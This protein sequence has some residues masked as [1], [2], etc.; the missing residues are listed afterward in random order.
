M[1]ETM[2][3]LMA[4]CLVFEGIEVHGEKDGQLFGVE[5]ISLLG[6]KESVLYGNILG[7]DN[8]VI[9]GFVLGEEKGA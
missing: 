6:K 3:H 9:L 5:V 2:I 8:S 7:K 4:Y 1:V